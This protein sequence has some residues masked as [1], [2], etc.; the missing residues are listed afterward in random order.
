MPHRHAFGFPVEPEVYMTYASWS[1]TQRLGRGRRFTG[2]RLVVDPD[3]GP[4]WTDLAIDRH[5]A[6]VITMSVPDSVSSNRNRS[7]GARMSSGR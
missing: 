4:L 5:T 2:Q 1:G 3:Q 7:P 6:S